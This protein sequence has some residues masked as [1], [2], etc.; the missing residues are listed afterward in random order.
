MQNLKI[1]LSDGTRFTFK[2]VSKIRKESNLLLFDY[3]YFNNLGIKEDTF[4]ASFN[5]DKILGYAISQ[6]DTRS[7]LDGLI[8]EL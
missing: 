1:W 7:E 4:N 2:E 6:D 8:D 5:L 3:V